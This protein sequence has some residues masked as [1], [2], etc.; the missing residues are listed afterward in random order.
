MSC[1]PTIQHGKEGGTE[2]WRVHD[3]Q[4]S[5]MYNLLVILYFSPSQCAN[6]GTGVGILLKDKR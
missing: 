2:K 4:G 6:L 3:P 5:E 1:K